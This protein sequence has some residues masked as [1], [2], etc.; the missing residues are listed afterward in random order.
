MVFPQV[1]T[2]GIETE[3]IVRHPT[4]QDQRLEIPT[5]HTLISALVLSGNPGNPK[6]C[7]MGTD[8]KVMLPQFIAL[9]D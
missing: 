6:E 2:L 8:L 4:L 9:S 3:F 7:P 5:Y 1:A